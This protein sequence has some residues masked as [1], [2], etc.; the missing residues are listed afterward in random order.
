MKRNDNQNN[1]VKWV[2]IVTDF[3]L[4]NLLLFL[5][6]WFYPKMADWDGAKVRMF[7][8]IF[9]I[10]LMISH[11]YYPPMI[12]LRVV[13][14]GHILRRVIKLDAIMVLLAYLIMKG[15]NL[16]EARIGV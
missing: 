8:I 11:Y 2:V 7:I 3:L 10:A 1:F 12:H 4:L 16:S 13:S 15:I 5:C 6:A 9:N 14:V